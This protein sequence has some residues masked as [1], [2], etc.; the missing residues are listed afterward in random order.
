VINGRLRADRVV[1]TLPLREMPLIVGAPEDVVKAGERLD[2]NMVAHR[3]RSPLLAPTAP[4]P[5][6]PS[7]HVNR[8]ELER[9]GSR[10]PQMR[11]PEAMRSQRFG[12]LWACRT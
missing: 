3:T 8:A 2:Y 6:K 7:D 11:R 4:A 9:H 10:G 5:T 12:P 1:S